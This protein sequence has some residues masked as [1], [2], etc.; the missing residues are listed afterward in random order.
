MFKS[1]TRPSPS[2]RPRCSAHSDLCSHLSSFSLTIFVKTSK[3]WYLPDM[4]IAWFSP[5]EW[6]WLSQ[7]RFMFYDCN[8]LFLKGSEMMKTKRKGCCGQ[9]KS[10]SPP[11]THWVRRKTCLGQTHAK[12]NCQIWEAHIAYCFHDLFFFI[13]KE[14][15]ASQEQFW[16]HLSHPWQ[17]ADRR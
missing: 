8:S 9:T 13:S 14:I 16:Y 4:A 15:R 10:V 5:Q 12:I 11:Y 17:G 1:P 7:L 2:C 6:T 3:K